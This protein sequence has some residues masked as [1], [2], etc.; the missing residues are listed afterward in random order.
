MPVWYSGHFFQV[1]SILDNCDVACAKVG[2]ED[3]RWGDEGGASTLF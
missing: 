1:L 2:I 3:E